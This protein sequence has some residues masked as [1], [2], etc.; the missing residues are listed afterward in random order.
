VLWLSL[1]GCSADLTPAWAWDPIWL[2]GADGAE[3]HGFQTW[4]IF[5]PKWPQR[6]RDKHFVCSVLVELEGVGSACD[7]PGCAAAWDVVPSVLETDCP[8]PALAESPLFTSLGRLALGGAY[9]AEDAPWPG[10]TTVSHADYGGGW[11]V[12]G[13]AYP[14]AYDRGGAGDPAWTGE[15]PFLFT[16]AAAFPLP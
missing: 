10:R 1:A 3:V 7:A 16:P 14:E 2:E 8:D 11:E 9:I 6:Q 15:D 5:G 13:W 12:H 4:E